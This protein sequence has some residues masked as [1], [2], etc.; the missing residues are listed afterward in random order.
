MSGLQGR[1]M[2]ISMLSASLFAF[3]IQGED[4]IQKMEKLQAVF[5]N[6]PLQEVMEKMTVLYLQ[7]REYKMQS[8][9]TRDAL[10]CALYQ[11][12][13]GSVKQMAEQALNMFTDIFSRE[14]LYEVYVK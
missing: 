13:Y 5:R 3:Y 7:T 12:S 6:K 14:P 2:L 11:I 1:V 4:S 9:P 8:N 10:E